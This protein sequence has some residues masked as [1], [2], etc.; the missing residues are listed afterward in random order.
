MSI[1]NTGNE[2][3]DFSTSAKRRSARRAYFQEI[4]IINVATPRTRE[5]R[6]DVDV[7]HTVDLIHLM[8]TPIGI[9]R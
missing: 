1:N 4:M 6:V 5:R 8:Y 2:M 9:S 3:R 7:L